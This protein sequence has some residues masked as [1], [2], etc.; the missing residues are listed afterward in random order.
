MLLEVQE[1]AI[2]SH[3]LLELLEEGVQGEM[4]VQEHLD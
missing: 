4:E 3:F 2:H 1:V